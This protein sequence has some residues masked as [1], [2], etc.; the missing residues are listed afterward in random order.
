MTN[1]DEKKF[2]H[3]DLHIRKNFILFPLDSLFYFRFN[4]YYFKTQRGEYNQLIM[5][6][7]NKKEN[8]AEIK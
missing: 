5:L 6:N 3:R 7:E 2:E 8:R 1:K 4:P